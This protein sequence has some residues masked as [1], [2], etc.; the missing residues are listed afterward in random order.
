MAYEFFVVMQKRSDDKLFAALNKTDERMCLL[1]EDA[2]KALS[3]MGSLAEHFHVVLLV[4]E[5]KQDWESLVEAAEVTLPATQARLEAVLLEFSPGDM[6][7]E[8]VAR[9]AKHQQPVQP[10]SEVNE[11]CD[12]LMRRRDKNPD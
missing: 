10:E 6:A 8:E 11:L 1:E 7:P 4:A 3:D 12:A 2:L 9:W 5:L